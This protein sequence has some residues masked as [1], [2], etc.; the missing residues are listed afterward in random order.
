V[1]GSDR[2]TNAYKT[3]SPLSG[4]EPLLLKP[5]REGSFNNS[6][7][8]GVNS[9]REVYDDSM[10]EKMDQVPKSIV[11]CEKHG[12]QYSILN[13]DCSSSTSQKK[14]RW[15]G[16]ISGENVSVEECVF[17]S[18]SMDGWKGTWTEGSLILQLIDACSH[19]EYPEVFRNST[20][21]GTSYMGHTF[22]EWNFDKK[23]LCEAILSS[24]VARVKRNWIMM[25]NPDPVIVVDKDG[26]AINI[27]SNMMMGDPSLTLE[28]FI[29]LYCSLGKEIL[30]EIASI[31]SRDP[32]S[33]RNGWADI[34]LWKD[35]KT[36]FI[37]V[38][39]PG[40]TLHESQYS[41]IKNF[42]R[43]LNLD[44]SVAVVVPS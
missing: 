38:K 18:L 27:D 3:I 6:A 34:T 20:I 22:E 23:L 21:N 35:G 9:K 8:D 31:F 28:N 25:S 7:S 37:E 24:N 4:M 33:H 11:D 26:W 40:D 5:L 12:I 1:P 41:H 13:M 14:R 36:K 15:L 32:Y 17:Q 10:R 29:G 19:D 30:Y 39:G 42:V 2:Q 44:Y 16:V 43:K